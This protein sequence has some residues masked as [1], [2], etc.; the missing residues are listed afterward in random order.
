MKNPTT[1]YRW[2]L[3]AL[4]AFL[5]PAYT[6]AQF[7]E[8]PEDKA[9]CTSIMVGKLASTDGSVMTSHSCDG[10]YRTWLNIVPAA[11]H[12]AGSTRKIQWGLLHTETP[13]DTRRVTVKGEIPQVAETYAYFNVAYPAMNQKQLAIGETTI[14]GRRDLIND[15][16]LFLIE[17]LQAIALERCSTARQAI[18]LMGDLAVKYGY[19][20]AGECLTIADKNEVWHFE[21]FGAGMNYT[22]AVWAAVRIPDDHVGVSANIPRISTIDL[23]KK[24]YYMASENI[25]TLAE[26]YGFWDPKSGEPF[27]MWKAYGGG[28]KA[29][30]IR[31]FFVLSTMA[32][33]LKLTQDVDELPFSVKPDKKVSVSDVFAYYRQTYE[34]TEFDATKNLLVR[35]TRRRPGDQAGAEAPM[36]KSP[37][38]NPY[39]G[40]D[41]RNLLNTLAPNTVQSQRTIAV[42]QCSYS[43]V[44]QV[45]GWLPDEIGGIAWFS[46]DN[47]GESPRIPIYSGVLSLPKSFE[48]CGQKNYSEES[49][50]WQ[51]RRTNRLAEVK[52][53]VTR[54]HIENG[55][56][57]LEEK[58]FAEI[59][60]IDKTALELYNAAKGKPAETD[61]RGNPKPEAY[62]VFLT[63]YSNDFARAAAKR[64]WEM[65]DYFFTLYARGI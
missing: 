47:P 31:E 14:S 45:R 35:D 34:G 38:A 19:G 16:G 32:P 51:F 12:A 30:S 36:M 62:R 20:D 60:A 39:M 7:I 58:A 29:F 11:K 2:L 53:G 13:W 63:N 33:S 41:M 55:V 21:I 6:T 27:K 44:I 54:T 8:V 24:D 48:L 43:Q 22:S 9:S 37:V 65:G 40:S 3:I 56:R 64:W 17:E 4:I 26:E 42:P 25:F 52:W 23:K 61:E 10:N 46:F 1:L 18:Q 15:D 57:E 49:A 50:I 5:L 28:R 59:P